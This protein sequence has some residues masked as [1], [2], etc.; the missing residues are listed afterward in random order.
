[1]RLFLILAALVVLVA[2]AAAVT[3]PGPA[4]F[5]AM[6]DE[7]IRTRVANAD[8]EARGDALPTLALAACKLRPSDCVAVVRQALDI[9]FDEGAFTTRV[10]VEGFR[11][12]TTCT[13]A[14]GRFFCER[15][16]AE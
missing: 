2:L 4:E 8:L 9:H 6:L 14:F 12:S 13:G 3:R 16:L 15:P 7:A 10:T 1:M 5:D 11:R